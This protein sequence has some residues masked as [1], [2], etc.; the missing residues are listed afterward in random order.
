MQLAWW[1]TTITTATVVSWDVCLQKK[2]EIMKSYGVFSSYTQKLVK[3]SLVIRL[4][5]KYEFKNKS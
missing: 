4:T 2:I 5:Q 1:V 3:S